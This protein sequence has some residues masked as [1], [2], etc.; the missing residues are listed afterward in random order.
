MTRR[1]LIASGIL[2]GAGLGGFIDGI[3]FHQLLQIHNMLSATVP[4]DTL[5]NSKINMFWDGVF[6]ALVWLMTAFGLAMLW[7]A[8]NRADVPWSGR[9]F[10]G[11][12]LMGWGLFNLIEGIIDHH[13]LH[14]HHVVER[15]GLSSYDYAFVGSG[16]VLIAL[17]AS[18]IRAGRADTAPRG[19][20]AMLDTPK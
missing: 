11:S 17:G 7:G 15:L 8:G 2:L 3:A 18:G 5:V 6:H 20:Q 12:L 4:P 1:P 13:I 16:I 19:A 10:A 9:T 14:I